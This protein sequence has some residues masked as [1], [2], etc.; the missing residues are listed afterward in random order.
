MKSVAILYLILAVLVWQY[1]SVHNEFREYREDQAEA[2]SKLRKEADTLEATNRITAQRNA[3]A[4]TEVKN[5]YE[6]ALLAADSVHTSRLLDLQQRTDYYRGLSEA[7]DSGCA[8]LAD[9]RDRL[10]GLVEE[11]RRLV[12]ELRQELLL[13]SDQLK[14]VKQ[15]LTADRQLI[16]GSD[17]DD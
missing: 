17:T 13:R 9:A 2:V 15:Q 6:T 10:D 11:G 7:A 16:E 14:I 12:V 5:D 8:E 1:I 4:L 3:V